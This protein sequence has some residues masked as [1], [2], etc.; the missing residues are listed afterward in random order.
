MN[1]QNILTVYGKELRDSLRDRRTLISMIVIPMLMIPGIMAVAVGVSTKMINKARGEVPTVMVLGGDDSPVLRAALVADPK[2]HLVR[3]A[4]NWRQQISDKQLRAA[5]EIPAGFDA[6]LDRGT[7]AEVKIY[8]YDG[9]LRSGF[10]VGEL[11][12]FLNDYREK[13]V[14]TRLVGRGLPAALVKPFEVK[15]Q[16]VA[17]P[18]KVGGNMI[19]GLIPY[20]FILL[21]Y[22]GAMYSA[23]DLTAG[24]KERGTMETI[25][26]S[27]VARTDLVLGKF[28]MVLTAS[29]TAALISMISMG[30]TFVVGG[31]LMGAPRMTAAAKAG[32]L[33]MLD[34]AGLLLVLAMVLPVAVLFSA[35]LLA[36]SLFAK[37]IKEASSYVSPMIILIIIPAMMG[38]MPGVELNARL[39]L[40]PILNIALVSKELVSGVFHWQYLALIFGSTC[41]YAAAALAFCVHL[42]NREEVLFRT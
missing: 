31:I 7:P 19:G 21:C 6:A 40:V 41:I 24:E 30:I 32:P 14:T 11:R 17:P 20:L 2:L 9:E 3:T 4:A 35:V 13:T 25:L 28:L 1:G 39:A 15:T 27:P 37:S 29:L 18:E 5:V 23:M 36:V 33:P 42:F 34:P 26:C 22:T 12:N 10:A 38:L 8:N 16:N